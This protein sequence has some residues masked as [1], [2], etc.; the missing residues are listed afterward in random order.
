M[1]PRIL[2]TILIVVAVFTAVAESKRPNIILAMADDQGWG[3]MG[4][5]G[6]KVL[7]TPVF[8][9][10]AKTGL[11]FDR[12]YAAAPVCSPTRASVLTGRHPNRMGCF[13]WG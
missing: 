2:F 10:M 8:D 4:Y 13:Q 7:K 5:M 12:F 11:R 9:E 1:K 3:D 6:H